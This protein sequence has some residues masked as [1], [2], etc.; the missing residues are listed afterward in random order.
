MKEIILRKKKVSFDNAKNNLIDFA[1]L[2]HPSYAANWHHHLLAEKLQGIVSGKLKRL[3]ISMPPRHGKTE[4]ASIRFGPWYLGHNPTH[5]V[6]QATYAAEFA[7]ENAKYSRNIVATPEFKNVFG[8]GL[9]SDSKAVSRWQTDKGG[10]YYAVGVG[11]P[12]TG[13]GAN[14]LI[15]DDPHKNRAEAESP[16]MRKNVLDWFKST[17][18]TRLEKNGS[19]IVIMTRWHEGD[20]VGSLLKSNEKWDYISLPAIAEEDEK[21]R[22]QGD[23]LWS[24]KFDL[25]ALNNIR[26]TI[27]S[28]E[29][30]SLY[31][32]R[33]SAA[34]GEI[35]KREWWKF[36][37]A[38]PIFEKIVHSWDT[39]FKK[40]L[41]NDFSVCTVWGV[42]Q[43]GYYLLYRWKK[44]VEFPE[45]KRTVV[46]LF[47][48]IPGHEIL[49]EDKASGQSLVQELQRETKLPIIP[50]KI[51][52]DKV[53]RAYAVTP[54]I[55][56]GNVYLPEEADW[57]LDYIDTLAAFP[58]AIHDDDVDSTTQALSACQNRTS[59]SFMTL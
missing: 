33:P 14:C 6:V 4:L 57:L 34:E 51:D 27:G 56:S 58:N 10:T 3:M 54:I 24:S 52:G 8:F 55:E 23:P 25:A 41:E 18:Y 26:E 37:R 49:I 40:G 5:K 19:V 45:L 32:Q 39:A 12:L 31:Q 9:A 47:H 7:E 59:Y 50:Y 22:R 17:A 1:R 48:Q 11:G 36:Y 43:N 21:Y 2:T 46:S 38:V 44:R 13:K 53:A 15:I 42:A 30:I 29:W 20:L 16:V 28:R 35:F